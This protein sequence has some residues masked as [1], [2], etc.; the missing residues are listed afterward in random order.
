ML[1]LFCMTKN[2]L[3]VL[4]NP[5]A[6]T[7]PQDAEALIKDV[8]RQCVAALEPIIV[9]TDDMAAVFKKVS[10]TAPEFAVWG[11][12]GTIA[13]ALTMSGPETRVLPL[14]GGT[15]NLLPKQIHGEMKTPEELLTQYACSGLEPRRVPFGQINAHRFYV[16]VICGQL[17]ELASVREALRHG[18]PIK[19]VSEL[20][21]SNSFDFENKLEAGFEHKG[22]Q[23]SD[24]DQTVAL[25]AFLRTGQ[26]APLEVGLLKSETLLDMTAAAFEALFVGWE[27]AASIDNFYADKI[28]VNGFDAEVPVTIDGEL[29]Q[30]SSPLKITVSDSATVEVL[31]WASR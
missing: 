13:C 14:P 9:D 8:A 27:N 3:P 6:R 5:A 12:D 26:Q 4:I 2:T 15:M 17:A 11:G 19:A 22:G 7:V 30:L 16:G 10:K 23:V 28:N 18:Q 29:H 31:A 1:R 25:A 24:V 20:L 21:D